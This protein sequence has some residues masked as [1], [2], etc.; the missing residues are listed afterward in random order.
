MKTHYKVAIIG[1]NGYVGRELLRLV[2]KHP[3]LKLLELGNTADCL[4]NSHEL[5]LI[6]LATPPAVSMEAAS[7]LM[8]TDVN[9]IDLS[10]AFRL[11]EETF[12]HWYGIQHDASVLIEK[13]CYGLS[14]WATLQSKSQLIANPGCYAT[15]ALMALLPLFKTK[16]ID[17]KS[18]IIDAKSGVSGS[19]K[20]LCAELMF[21]EVANNFYPYKIGKHQHKPEIE[22]AIDDF[23]CQQTKITLTT[24]ILPI[25]RGLAM[26][27]YLQAAPSFTT[28]EDIKEAIF[29]A[30]HQHYQSYPFIRYQEVGQGRVEEDQKLLAL[31]HVNHTPYC[32]LG[33]F[34]KEKQ[35]ILFSSIDNLLKG[36]ASQAIENLNARYE[37]PLKTGLTL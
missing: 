8:T 17:K 21:C 16:V 28:D 25:E 10:G 26:T 22:K 2:Q 15:S 4:Q 23:A 1:K 6:F 9:I 37:F 35:I 3:H 5:D 13:A 29:N 33:F 24:A 7:I 18:I 19:G 30:F 34:V 20:K 32:H 31:Q 11:P 27:I 14:P 36:A 12:T